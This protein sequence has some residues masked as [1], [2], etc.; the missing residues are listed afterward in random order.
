MLLFN[1]ETYIDHITLFYFMLLELHGLYQFVH[2][3][4]ANN[5]FF[6]GYQCKKIE[7]YKAG[8]CIGN[9]RKFILQF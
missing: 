2:E 1:P 8:S 7:Q 5:D 4:G 6:V 9:T 3:Y